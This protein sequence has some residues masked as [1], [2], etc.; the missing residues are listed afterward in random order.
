[1]MRAKYRQRPEC[2]V[3]R[4]RIRDDFCIVMDKTDR[5]ENCVCLDCRDALK[6]RLARISPYWERKLINVVDRAEEETPYTEYEI[7]ETPAA[8]AG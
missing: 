3:C 2:R 7:I 6:G 4:K 8:A 1:M 5:F